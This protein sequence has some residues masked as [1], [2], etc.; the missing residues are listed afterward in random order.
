MSIKSLSGRIKPRSPSEV[1][2]DRY[3]H[4]N[5]ENVEPN[6]GLPAGDRYFLKGDSDGTRYW[7]TDIDA[8]ANAFVRYDY[9][10]ANATAV[11]DANLASISNTFLDF[12]PVRDTILV[13]VNGVLISPGSNTVTGDYFL[14][15]NSVILDL[16]TDPGDIVTIIPINDKGGGG[17][18]GAATAGP[19]GPPGATGSSFGVVGPTGATGVRGATGTTGST[20][21]SGPPGIGS[22]GDV[23]PSGATGPSGPTG[24]TGPSGATGPEGPTGLPSTVP[25]PPGPDGNAAAALVIFGNDPPVPA[26]EGEI[27]YDTEDTNRA[28]TYYSNAWIEL[29]PSAGGAVGPTGA[30]GLPS[31]VPG[32]TGSTGPS[33]PTGPTGATGPSGA[34][35][36]RGDPG[37]DGVDGI[38]TPGSPGSTGATGPS[39]PP[40][41]VPGPSGATGPASTQPGPPGPPGSTGATGPSGPSGATG[42]ASTVPGGPGGPGSTGAT[43]PRGATGATGPPGSPSTVSGPPGAPSIVPGPPGPPGP[44]STVL[45]PPGPPGPPPDT[46][47][48]VTTNTTQSISGTKTFSTTVTA[49]GFLSTS[50]SFNFD[51]TSSIYKYLQYS[52]IREARIDITGWTMSR[53]IQRAW[54]DGST[55]TYFALTAPNAIFSTSSPGFSGTTAGLV[56]NHTNDV[57]GVGYD[58]GNGILFAGVSQSS[59]VLFTS[60]NVYKPIG[61]TFTESSDE[62][63]KTNIRNYAKGLTDVINL[64]PVYYTLLDKKTKEPIGNGVG[65]IAQEVKQTT[66]DSMVGE[67]SDGFYTLN[68]S[69]LTF[70]LVNAVKELSAK[71]EELKQEIEILKGNG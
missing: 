39:G 60:S 68:S 4:L 49:G 21:P 27:W 10:T 45:G 41:T 34:T 62:R 63:L 35:G 13:W 31:T 38:G 65:L 55:R 19:P 11:F 44:P 18:G 54:S 48:F 28:Y 71:V 43:G 61:A 3:R 40:S 36:P 64:R 9:I 66:M 1:S 24:A 67:D 30:T 17:F 51:S 57:F 23:G 32:P 56:Y 16:P 33:G 42:P 8:Q 69:E 58:Q 46:S 6:L 26:E 70:A 15:A 22:T 7:S 59:N 53:W 47:Q 20:G 14:E 25:G 50:R 12:D 29:S 5:L 2:S 37:Q 52:S